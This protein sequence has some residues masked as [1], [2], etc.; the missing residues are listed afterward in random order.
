MRIEVRGDDLIDLADEFIEETKPVVVSLMNR[1]SNVV[2]TAAQRRLSA[3]SGRTSAPGES[4]SMRSG[5]LFRSLKIVGAT[6][7]GRVVRGGVQSDHP[8]AGNLEW[9]GAGLTKNV[10]EGLH[11]TGAA[12]KRL[13]KD[14]ADSPGATRM[15]AARPFL[16]PAEEQS[17]A[18]VTRIL[19]EGL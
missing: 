18:E 11:L 9:G 2:L 15:I 13:R 10:T 5:A 6:V 19:N 7:K 12:R 16:R 1:V 14:L 17:E 4:P 3:V 8:G